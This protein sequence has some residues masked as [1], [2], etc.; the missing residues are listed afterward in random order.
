MPYGQAAPAPYGMPMMTGGVP[1]QQQ[2]QLYPGSNPYGGMPPAPQQ[3]QQ[4]VGAFAPLQQ[5]QQ[6]QQLPHMAA[7][8][9]PPPSG[10][11]PGVVLSPT[12]PFA[13]SAGAAPGAAGA[14]S[15]PFGTA[16]PGGASVD[17]EWNSFFA[18]CVFDDVVCSGRARVRLFPQA[19]TLLPPP[20]AVCLQGLGHWPVMRQGAL[21]DGPDSLPRQR[22]RGRGWPC[23]LC[24]VGDKA[25]GCEALLGV[26]VVAV[27]ARGRIG[28]DAPA[29]SL[30]LGR[31]A[32]LRRVRVR[33][34]WL[35]RPAQST[36]PNLLVRQK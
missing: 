20:A 30:R 11:D 12:N 29:V 19:D 17:Q 18:R 28:G 26:S 23:V 16:P 27:V 32:R 22:S 24:V 9:A 4:Q 1:Q 21:S 8:S 31:A 15:N 36:K 34:S 14:A 3:Q 35:V 13:S 5:Q 25:G 33:G 7:V 2:Q 10:G 6:P